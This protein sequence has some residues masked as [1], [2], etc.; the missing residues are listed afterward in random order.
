MRKNAIS[1]SRMQ[2]VDD[3]IIQQVAL[4]AR[5]YEAFPILLWGGAIVGAFDLPVAGT[6][7]VP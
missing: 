3:L 4:V 1:L 5:T 6:F 7:F 2:Q